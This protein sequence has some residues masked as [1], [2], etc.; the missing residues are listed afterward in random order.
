MSMKP[1]LL[2][3]AI[4]AGLGVSAASAEGFGRGGPMGAERPSFSELD[5]D[6]DGALS[7]AEL[8]APM[9]ERFAAADA[10]GDGTLTA[11]ELVAMVEGRRAE[12]MARMAERMIA[13]FDAN[14]DGVLSPD[15]MAT[16]PAPA[17]MFERLDTDG[18]GTISED[19]FAAVGERGRGGHGMGRGMGHDRGER[20]G[21]FGHRG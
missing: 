7:E 14:D 13:R 4:A 1:L 18:D 21:F 6:G 11:E 2:I 17:T 3:S 9:A 10:D 16:P 19:E 8:Q 12:Q 15:E 5:T 20:G